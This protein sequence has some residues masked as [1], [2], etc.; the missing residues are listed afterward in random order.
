MV[1]HYNPTIAEDAHRI[2]NTKT[3][4]MNSSEVSPFIQPTI[5]IKRK[6][7]ICR[8]AT[9]T[10]TAAAQTIYTTPSDKDF[11]LVAAMLSVAK[12]ATSTSQRTVINATVDGVSKFILVIEGIATTAQFDSISQNWPIPIKVDRGTIISL[13]NTGG[14]SYCSSNATIQGYTVETIAGSN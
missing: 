3:G 1:K 11:Y 13:Q 6:C 12:D 2:L 10:N 7:N 8:N 9:A 4:D 14:V 5:E